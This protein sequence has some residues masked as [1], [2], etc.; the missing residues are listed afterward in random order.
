MQTDLK[1]RS[2][3]PADLCQTDFSAHTF[4]LP[5]ADHEDD[6]Y[7]YVHDLAEKILPC[8]GFNDPVKGR[9]FDMVL[10]HQSGIA[11]ELTPWD[12][13]RSTR[14][15]ALLS[16]PGAAWSSLNAEE[17]RDLIIDIRNWPGFYRTTRWDPQITVVNPPRTIDQVIEDVAA[18]RLWATKFTTQMPYEKRD[19][20][21]LLIEPPTQYFGSTQSNVRLRIYDHGAK[22]DWGVPS[23]RVEAQLRK[24]I[25]DRH[26]RRLAERCYDERAAEPLFIAAE[27]LT[28]KDALSQ[29]ADLRDTSKW[30]GRPK[31]RKWAQTAPKAGWWEEM[32][33]HEGN[34]LTVAQKAE[35][36]WD[37]TID[38]M[39]DQYGRKLFLWS[40]R[41]ALVR[42]ITSAEVMEQLR[43]NC[44]ARLKKGDDA[45]VA[46]QVPKGLKQAARDS[47]RLAASEIARRQEMAD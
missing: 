24:E 43:I 14:G 29:H 35:L 28:V 40:T 16:L 27:T 37:K 23:L 30:E 17:R 32:L 22:H 36:D 42:G 41:E 33:Q 45:L 9:Y 6:L 20:N 34:P 10:A 12:S 39:I 5:G 7:A 1:L 44:A 21:G 46:S 2:A 3:G 31:P 19:K 4:K 18:G 15:C 47:C 26:F 8:G 25:A 38:A 13:E 11:L